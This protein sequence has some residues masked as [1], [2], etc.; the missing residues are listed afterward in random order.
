[1]TSVFPESLAEKIIAQ[2]IQEWELK[3]KQEKERQDRGEITVYPFLTISRDLGC[4]EEEILPL[5]EKTLGWKIYG[6]N[7]LDYV[8]A[9][10]N[11]SRSFIETLDEHRQQ[12]VDQWVH[13][14]IHSGSILQE[15]YVVKISRL[16]KVIAA[17]ESAIFL[18]RGSNYILEA[19]KEGLRIRLTAPLE[20][21]IKNIAELRNIPEKKAET[22]VRETDQKRENF[23]RS[24]F[25]KNVHECFHFDLTF[26]TANITNEMI[27]KTVVLIFDEKKKL[28]S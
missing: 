26:N 6:R 23:I 4:R 1:M 16:M 20:Q 13:Y 27:C 14:L 5:L 22:I 8:A 21:R 19:K 12:M 9:R 17:Q 24:Y 28:G 7:L 15:D 11:L 3:R 10:D 2:K 18:G 25:G